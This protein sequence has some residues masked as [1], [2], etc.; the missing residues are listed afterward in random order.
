MGIPYYGRKESLSGYTPYNAP[1][2]APLPSGGHWTADGYLDATGESPFSNTSQYVRHRD[3][4]DTQGS[5]AWDTWSSPYEGCN[6]EMYYDDVTSLGNKYNLVINNHLRG[7]GIFALNYGGGAPEL[8]LLVLTKVGPWLQ[9]ALP[10]GHT[11]PP[12]PCAANTLT[13]AP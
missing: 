7:I 12:N 6:R 8:W 13:G 9:A 1:A 2:N 4:V 5:T 3:A 10:P 11:P